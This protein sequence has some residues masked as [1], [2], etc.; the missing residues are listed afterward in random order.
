MKFFIKRLSKMKIIL[1][2]IFMSLFYNGFSQNY[3]SNNS[4]E[5]KTIDILPNYKV[6]ELMGKYIN[7]Y[8]NN[9][10]I[11]LPGYRVQISFGMNKDEQIK[12]RANF[13]TLFPD[14]NAYLDYIQ[15]N[16]LVKVGD[17]RTKLEAQKMLNTIKINFPTSYIIE[18]VIVSNISNKQ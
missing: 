4:T 15:P 18:D 6:N 16:F 9:R 17:F 3:Y 1:F 10:A 5:K 2:M 7:M 11:T 13:L 12:N 14:V 8:S